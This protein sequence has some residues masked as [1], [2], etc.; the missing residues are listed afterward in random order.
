MK[1]FRLNIGFLLAA[2]A[3]CVTLL[4]WLFL[5]GLWAQGS[6]AG[7]LALVCVIG[8][9]SLQTRLIRMMSIFVSALEMNDTTLRI[10]ADGDSELKEM[11]AAMNRISQLYR[12]N[13]R[14]LETRKLYYDRI[15]KIMTHEMRNGIAPLIALTADMENHPERYQGER[16]T[17]ASA[18]LHGQ[19]EGIKRFLDSY[20]NLTHLPEPEIVTVKAH[21]YF[22]TIKRLAISE[23][24]QRGLSETIIGFIVPEDMELNFDPALIN[25]VMLNLLRNAFDAVDRRDGRVE[26]VVTVS[27]M[28][29]YI[30]VKD[31]GGGIPAEI[32]ENLFQPFYTTKADGSGVGLCLCRQIVRRHGGD[33]QIQSQ[34][35]RG[36]SVILSL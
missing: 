22:E 5:S 15:L 10:E 17:E 13:L 23:L 36:T 20:Y 11:S 6:L 27:D 16:L 33:I 32:M 26:V 2:L 7:I 3:G 9:W 35:C 4:V 19:V 1:R 31:N 8:I 18:L 21:D 24:R 34:P 29:P 30:T 25:Q 28:R 14:E 12:S